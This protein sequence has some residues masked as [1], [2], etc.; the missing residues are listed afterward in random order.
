MYGVPHLLRL[1]TRLPS[2]LQTAS[3]TALELKRLTGRVNDLVK[4]V[5]GMDAGDMGFRYRRAT[6]EEWTQQEKKKEE[7][8]L[9]EEKEILAAELPSGDDAMVTN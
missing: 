3:L 9:L 2:L 1:F 6:E 8:K 7:A 5:G 4:F